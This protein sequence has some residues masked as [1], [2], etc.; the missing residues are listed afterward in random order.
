MSKILYL[1]CHEILEFDEVS[2]LHE[3]GHEVFSPGAYVEPANRGDQN[4][5]PSIP[6]LKYDPDILEQFH[7]I[8]GQHPGQDAK[9]RPR[10]G[11]GDGSVK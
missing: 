7:R 11:A 5:R 2:L 4:L 10:T 8:A 6:G 3:L 1:S 9:D